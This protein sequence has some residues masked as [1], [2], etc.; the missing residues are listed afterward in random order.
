MSDDGRPW[1]SRFR[2]CTL[3]E[4]VGNERAVGQL[5]NWI[6]SWEEG[7][8]EQR[9]AFLYGPPGVGK[10]C[11]VVAIANDLGFDLFEVNASD[12]RTKKRLEEL[13]GRA[14]MQTVTIAGK[15]RMILFDELEG[16]SGREDRGGIT[17]IASL[18][19]GT[20]V[21]IV[22]VATA[23]GEMWE[24]K[25]RSLVDLS[26]IVEYRPVSFGAVLR[27][28]REIADELGIQVEE[29]VLEHLA[30][31]SQGDLR[32]TIND[33]ESIARGA[34]R[35][36]MA[37]AELLCERDRSD[38]TPDA[39]M[40]MFSSKSLLD[41][42]RVIS[43]SLINYDTLF[44]WIYENLPIVLDDLGDLAEGMDALALADI[45]QTRGQ[46]SQEYRLLKYMFNDMTGGVALSR[47]R[48]EG[49]GLVKIVRRKVTEL[50]LQPMSFIITERPEGLQIKPVRYLGNDWR[51]VNSALRG[52]GAQWVREGGCWSIPY[53]RPPQ[54]I[55]RYRR[56]WHSRRRLRSIAERV[57]EKCHVSTREA[58]AEVI[59][60]MKVI[61]KDD[62]SM[63][64]EISGWL[65][66]D[67]KETKWL[68][69]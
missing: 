45:H 57:A 53:F 17:A 47:S 13:V 37:E 27:R 21:P 14:S 39:L 68:K 5:R 24:D 46:R 9:A 12:Y 51:P 55:W 66:L 64:K 36:T 18:I 35:V 31:R 61:F 63:A 28:L 33:L 10:T 41:A 40:K 20:R 58:V 42:R 1:A 8:P 67:D 44:D 50:G 2:P 11:S 69:S 49:A 34:E 29:E 19:N 22:L 65:E 62:A 48:S 43:S 54:L 32:S 7:L 15:R 59:P 16:V 25:F 3:K 23:I 52:M 6:R 30:H 60:L 4:I 26:L 38:Y 56:T